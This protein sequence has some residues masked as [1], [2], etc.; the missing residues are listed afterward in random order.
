MVMIYA[1]ILRLAASQRV[2][3]LAGIIGA[4]LLAWGLWT[5]WLSRHDAA[6]IERHEA[7]IAAAVASATAEA[8]D[9][10]NANDAKRRADNA[11]ADEQ[12]KGAIDHAVATD[13]VGAKATVGPA[14]RA[15]LDELR[16]RK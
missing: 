6:V 15:A 16:K 2:R 9:A 8:N 11:R 5:L 4:L 7:P 13:P 10:A 12:L 14:T 3:M 1:L